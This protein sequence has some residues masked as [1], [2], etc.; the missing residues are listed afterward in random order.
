MG[1]DL[2]GDGQEVR[3]AIVGAGWMGQLHA[4]CI[5]AD[6]QARVVAVADPGAMARAEFGNHFPEVK[7]YST[8]TELLAN[9][10]C[11]AVTLCTPSGLHADQA[12]ESVAAGR[13]VVV[14]KPIAT[15]PGDASRMVEAADE[16]GV[17][18]SVIHQYR[19]TRDALRLQRVV[20]SGGLGRVLLA[21]AFVFCHRAEQYFTQ[22]GSWRSSWESNGGGVLI[23]QAIHAVDLIQWMFGPPEVAFAV[24][25][26]LVHDSIEV[27]DTITA[28]LVFADGMQGIIQA[29]QAASRDLPLRIEVI[30]TRG[31][32]VFERSRLTAWEVED[33]RGLLDDDEMLRL[34]PVTGT[35]EPFG[36]AHK[37]QFA[38]ISGALLRGSQPEV[39]GADAARSL[40]I[41]TSIYKSAGLRSYAL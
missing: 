20:R 8:L 41:V 35:D 15:N 23:N 26:T 30:G 40:D 39:S 2:V 13:H 5:Q 1:G 11:D 14:E 10:D 21:N 19:F 18:L 16:A 12:V 4:G 9:E 34:P 37:R 29:T 7:A 32:A 31:R 27:E 25:G 3:F 17:T 24:G 38:A 22:N 28:A 6:P 33:D 36:L